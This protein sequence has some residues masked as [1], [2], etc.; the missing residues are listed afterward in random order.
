MVP[1]GGVGGVGG[2]GGPDPN[3]VDPGDTP[4]DTPG[5]S[6][7]GCRGLVGV[8]SGFTKGVNSC[9]SARTI[10]EEVAPGMEK[11]TE[12]MAKEERKIRYGIG[13]KLGI[14]L[15]IRLKRGGKG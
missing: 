10:P 13:V 12:S 9:I 8:R 14:S 2:P 4:G 11:E 15:E 1:D 3:G 7:G 5:D 6:P